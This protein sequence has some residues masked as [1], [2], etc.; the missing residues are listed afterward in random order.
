MINILWLNELSKSDVSVVGEKG[1][2]LGEMTKVGF[3]VPEGFVIT[4]PAFQA[5]KEMPS[6][7]YWI[8]EYAKVGIDGVSID[9][10]DLTQLMLGVDR[11]S[12]ICAELFNESDPSV[13]D[14]IERIIRACRTSGLTSSLCGQTPSNQPEFAEA[15]VRVGI[16]SISVNLD[17]VHK[18]RVAIARAEQRL[19]GESARKELS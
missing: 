14:A 8:P 19:V 7:A 9:S 11:D 3:A 17:A 6:V 10:N 4:A 13:L 5:A 18:A 16:T 1:A 12:A 15:L 2:N